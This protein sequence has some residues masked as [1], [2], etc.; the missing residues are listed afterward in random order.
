M[1]HRKYTKPCSC[2][3][4]YNAAQQASRNTECQAWAPSLAIVYSP[5]QRFDSLFMPC[6]ALKKG[7]LFS[8]LHKPFFGTCDGNNVKKGE[9]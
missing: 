3:V 9:C 5:I 2:N 1:E 8:E 4:N 6:E 7:T